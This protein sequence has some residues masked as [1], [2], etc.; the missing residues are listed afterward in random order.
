MNL[1][2]FGDYISKLV[3]GVCSSVCDKRINFTSA[4]HPILTEKDYYK[5]ILK[6]NKINTD[7]ESLKS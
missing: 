3:N 4:G 6:D 2:F 5:S 7:D 1:N